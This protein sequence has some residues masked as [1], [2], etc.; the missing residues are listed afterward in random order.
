MERYIEQ[1]I[2][3]NLPSSLLDVQLA[4]NALKDYGHIPDNIKL[5]IEADVRTQAFEAV[6]PGTIMTT[7]QAFDRGKKEF[8][9]YGFSTTEIYKKGLGDIAE[10]RKKHGNNI[11]FEEERRT[12]EL[13]DAYALNNSIVD[14]SDRM[15][16]NIKVVISPFPKGAD[17]KTAKEIGYF[18]DKEIAMVRVMEFDPETDLMKVSQIAVEKTD[19]EM[20][21]SLVSLLKGEKIEEPISA[22]DILGTQIFIP[23][24]KV[25]NGVVDIARI[26]DRY[27]ETKTGERHF[28]GED[29]GYAKKDYQVIVENSKQAESLT[30][31]IVN[32]LVETNIEL[33]KSLING[34]ATDFIK[35]SVRLTLQQTKDG[36][37]LLDDTKRLV[38]S[39][40]LTGKFDISAAE[41]LKDFVTKSDY[42]AM[43]CLTNRDRANEVFNVDE[44]TNFRNEYFN[45]PYYSVADSAPLMPN[46]QMELYFCGSMM[47]I[48]RSEIGGANLGSMSSG[49]FTGI[50]R[51][52]GSKFVK[53]CGNCKKSIGK[54]ISSGYVCVCGGTYRGC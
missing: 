21:A 36:K 43:L 30:Q 9:G 42:L 20:F 17:K 29:I 50:V 3:T 54:Y 51:E 38:L 52:G 31:P 48:N 19:L 34:S 27:L 37:S 40:S 25:T 2:E 44:V 24:G 32:H 46:G 4:L 22:T 39:E 45:D 28:L 1:D 53:N 47:T 15:A 16:E 12:I 41:A 33:A 14:G 18:A 10:L 7:Y 23:K 13:L 49:E 5:Y 26:Y 35:N 11:D 6:A 8:V